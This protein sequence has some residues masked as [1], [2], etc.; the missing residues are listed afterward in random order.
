MVLKKIPSDLANCRCNRD[1][2]SLCYRE[3]KKIKLVSV[4]MIP[5][6]TRA[7]LLKKTINANRS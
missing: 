7:K 5:K 3:T 2:A 4:E 1:L 6:H